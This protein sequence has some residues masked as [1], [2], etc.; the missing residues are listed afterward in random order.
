MSEFETEFEI[1]NFSD[2]GSSTLVSSNVVKFEEMA[3]GTVNILLFFGLVASIYIKEIDQKYRELM[4]A[5][6]G[7]LLALIYMFVGIM[8]IIKQGFFNTSCLLYLTLFLVFGNIGAIYLNKQKSG[9]IGGAKIPVSKTIMGYVNGSVFIL[10][11]LAMG[12]YNYTIRRSFLS[13]STWVMPLGLVTWGVVH[14]IRESELDKFKKTT[15]IDLTEQY[16]IIPSVIFA[17]SAVWYMYTS[18]VVGLRGEGSV[19]YNY[20]I[21]AMICMQLTVITAQLAFDPTG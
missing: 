14:L 21:L 1:Q 6:F 5:G 16:Y 18:L 9:L 10:A 13:P 12:V 3:A 7:F 20:L 4:F 17:C 2:I 15:K 8:C 11:G 19:N